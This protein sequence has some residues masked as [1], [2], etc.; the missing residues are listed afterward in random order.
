MQRGQFITLEGIE[1]VGKSTQ[2]EFIQQVLEALGVPH[3]IITRE[4]GGTPIAES[5]RQI[6]L[7][8]H[9]E[10]MALE[11]ELLLTFASRA[12]HIHGLIR[13]SLDRGEWVVC[14]RY[15]DTT[16]AYQGAG[17]GMDFS[18]IEMLEKWICR[19]CMPD[20]TLL[21]DAPVPLALSRIKNRSKLD[22]YESEEVTFFQ[23]IREYYL[24]RAKTFPQ[25]FHI[26]EAS[27]SPESVQAHIEAILREFVET[28]R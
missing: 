27:F 15:V 18:L 23:R 11:T 21:F 19:D 6:L 10:P 12:Q 1:G 8:H 9:D 5:I 4:T 13:P 2:V 20:L 28:H 22:R 14:D 17:R 24:A 25:R 3:V 16:Y 7:V 26:I